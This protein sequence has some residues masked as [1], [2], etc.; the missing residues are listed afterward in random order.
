MG[1]FD[2]V[3]LATDFDNTLIYTEEA[4]R[5]GGT[6]PELSRRNREALEYFTA[7][8]GRFTIATGRALPAFLPYAALL[9]INAPGIVCNGAGIYDFRAEKYLELALLDETALRRGQA[10]LEA[11]PSVGCEIYH[12]DNV[13]HS[14]QPNEIT[15]QHE[16]LTHLVTEEMASLPEVPLPVAKLLFEEDHAVLEVAKA[17]LER[18]GWGQDYEL[19]FSGRCLLEMTRKGANKG[20]MLVRLAALLGV[21]PENVYCAGD[22]ANDLSMLQAAAEGFAPANCIEAVRT[23]GATLVADARQDAAAEIIS[24]LDRR[25]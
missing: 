2:G 9:P 14:V 25:Y 15:R 3:L 23:S 18:M 24:I 22:E 7:G 4:L 11:F 10:L 16:H 21:A 5:T 19:I 6:V 1:K 17:F 13:I 8:G 12:T 20:G